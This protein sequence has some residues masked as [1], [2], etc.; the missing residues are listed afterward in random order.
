VP[1]RDAVPRL[2]FVPVSGAFGMGEFA[3]SSAIARAAQQRW[4]AA[5]IHF[6]LSRQA[7][8][9]AGAPFPVTL[10]PSSATF[11]SAAVVDLI[12]SW[13]PHVVLFDNAGRT[14]QLRAAQRCGARVVYI[15]ARA[16]QRRKAFRLRWMRLIDEHW[17]AYPEFI[18]GSLTL[19]ERLK[20]RLLGRPMVRYLDVIFSREPPLGGA[21][22]PSGH[23]DFVLLVPGG[24][25]GHPG[26]ED[27]SE[28][29]SRAGRLLAAGGIA[30]RYVGPVG[31]ATPTGAADPAAA[32]G[33]PLF[34]PLGPL[35]QS[36]LAELMRRARLTVVN[37][38][39]TLLQAIACGAAC[40]AVPIALDQRQ[41]I[42]RC[43][44]AGVAVQA[45]LDAREIA[46][47]VQ[48]LLLDESSRAALALRAQ[49]LALA[50]GIEVALSVLGRYIESE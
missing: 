22:A 18:A 37:G 1:L 12:R 19:T 5:L 42:R 27:A 35:P 31:V 13:R 28:Q 43:V 3:R 11:H 20:R 15:S 36:E 26:A 39:S 45:A 29:F 10:L 44:A 48:A 40:V 2:L 38:G 8:Y 23:G 16:R 17:I 34:Q 33:S 4:P 50:D 25:T 6:V 32:A 7:P 21:L 49:G 47:R 14:A 9:A 46:A 24:G 30:V 41:R